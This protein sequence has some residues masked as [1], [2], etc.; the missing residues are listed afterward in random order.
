MAKEEK[1]RHP[2]FRPTRPIRFYLLDGSEFTG[3]SGI[4]NLS[5]E[6]LQILCKDFIRP[7]SVL[8][9]TIDTGKGEPIEIPGRV[10]WVERTN[11]TRAPHQVGVMFMDLGESQ[12][13][14]LRKLQE[15]KWWFGR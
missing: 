2:R 14:K 1:R 15:K 13:E 12:R 3:V 10:M 7:T 11:V 4:Q 5:E 8:R 6:G 9:I